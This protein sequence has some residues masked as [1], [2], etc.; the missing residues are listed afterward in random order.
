[1]CD[2]DNILTPCIFEKRYNILRNREDL[3]HKRQAQEI[4]MIIEESI[5]EIKNKQVKL[6][7]ASA[8]DKCN[9]ILNS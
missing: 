5:R 3:L 8:A 2:N 6:M 7:L 9:M 4:K 1:M